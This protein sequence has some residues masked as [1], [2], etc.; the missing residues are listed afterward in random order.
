[1]AFWQRPGRKKIEPAK[2]GLK[3]ARQSK[4]ERS[5]LVGIAVAT[6]LLWQ[7]PIGST[8]LYPFT[9]LATWFHEMGHGLAAAALGG[10]FEQ[11]VIFPDGSGYARYSSPS[12]MMA[13]THALIAAAGLVG[14][15]VAGAIMIA[16]SR[17]RPATRWLLAG[18]GVTLILST[19]IW[20][21]SL[22]GWIVLPLFAAATLLVAMSGKDRLQRFTIELLGVQAAISVWRDVRY[23]F[24]DGAFVGGEYAPSD[25]AVIEEALLLPYWIWG[26]LITA[27]IVGMIWLALRF[28]VR[29]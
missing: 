9:L 28:A 4:R 20:V 25:T 12:D 14:P 17:S 11:L 16:G 5:Y 3:P 10:D 7:F 1:M 23:L 27:A 18:L 19:L 26:G 13:V 15:A 29:D 8:L 2:W 22:A 6:V 24:S 21:R